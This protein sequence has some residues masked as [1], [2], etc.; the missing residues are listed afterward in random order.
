M[1]QKIFGIFVLLASYL[2][3]LAGGLHAGNTASFV[4]NIQGAITNL[5]RSPELYLP[6][7]GVSL[8]L[9]IGGSMLLGFDECGEGFSVEQGPFNTGNPFRT[10]RFEGGINELNRPSRFQGFAD[11]AVAQS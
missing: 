7:I 8:L 10:E 11:G 5:S 6:Y 2:V 4:D 9:F 3:I 1:S